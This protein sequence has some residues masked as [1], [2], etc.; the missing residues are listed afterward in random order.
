[1]KDVNFSVN[2][3]K[4]KPGHMVYHQESSRRINNVSYQSYWKISIQKYV[5]FTIHFERVILLGQFAG[6]CHVVTYVR[7]QAGISGVS[8]GYLLREGLLST[9]GSFRE[10]GTLSCA[11]TMT[12]EIFFFLM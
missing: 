7:C 12:Q 8:Q 10:G 6:C 2:P 11:T 4:V 3:R 5:Q 1:M 9:G